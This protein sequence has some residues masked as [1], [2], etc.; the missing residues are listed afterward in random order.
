MKSFILIFVVLTI[1]QVG[2]S[3]SK[4]LDSI[5]ITYVNCN[6]ETIIGISCNQ[7][8]KQFEDEKNYRNLSGTEVIGFT[9]FIKSFVKL[10]WNGIDVRGKIEFN[11]Q[12]KKYKYCFDRFGKFSNGIY[13]YEN[14]QLFKLIKLAIPD[15][16]T[17]FAPKFRA[18]YNKSVT[19]DKEC[20]WQNKKR[21]I[22]DSLK[23]TIALI[24][25]EKDYYI[26]TV[27][28]KRYLPCNFPS[29]SLRSPILVSGYILQGFYNE[30]LIATPLRLSE[31]YSR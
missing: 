18:V 20:F 15:F 21:K 23:N 2:F 1:T 13:F 10:K 5:K 31:V 17:F 30:K 6:I 26:L 16:C 28:G 4:N 24:S 14:I 12:G 3:Q 9:K 7:F 29:I 27:N 11:M 22:V 19:L 25:K 8:D